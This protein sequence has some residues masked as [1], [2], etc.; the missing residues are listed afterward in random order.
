MQVVDWKKTGEYVEDV[1]GAFDAI[2]AAKAVTDKPSLIILQDDHRLAGPERS[3]TPARSTARRSAPMSCAPSRRCSASTPSKTFE[4]ASEV[5]EHTR[6]AST[7]ARRQHAEWQKGFDAWAAANPERKALFD[8]L[9]P[10]TPAGSRRPSRSSRPGKDVSTR[11]AS[12]KV[13]NALA[14]ATQLWGGSADFAESNN[15]TIEGAASFVPSER[16]THEWTGN[17]YGRVLHFGIREHAMAAIINGIV[18]HGTDRVRSA[19]P[20]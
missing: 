20:S 5:I 12:G 14:C 8:R 19:A 7:A 4:V 9:Q 11:A 10:A 15:T 16:S 2:E 17:K 6:K 18:L 3:R 1:A 13:L